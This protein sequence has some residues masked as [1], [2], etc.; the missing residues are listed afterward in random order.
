MGKAI[1]RHEFK[2]FDSKNDA[3]MQDEAEQR[4]DCH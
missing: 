3:A 4:Q 1:A 2:R